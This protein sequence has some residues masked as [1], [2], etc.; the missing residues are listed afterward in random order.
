MILCGAAR[1]L[2]QCFGPIT[3]EG[4]R[5]IPLC[6]RAHVHTFPRV[7]HLVQSVQCRLVA[8]Q[9]PEKKVCDFILAGVLLH[10]LSGCAMC[11][12]CHG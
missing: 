8:P 6:S 1:R 12:A 5:C 3:Q 7:T 4:P 10:I 2:Q 11:W 9:R